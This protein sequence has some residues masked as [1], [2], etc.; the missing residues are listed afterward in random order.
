[1]S[2]ASFV[3]KMEILFTR[4]FFQNTYFTIESVYACAALWRERLKATATDLTAVEV[5]PL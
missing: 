2:I 3:V 1:M 4:Y 5:P